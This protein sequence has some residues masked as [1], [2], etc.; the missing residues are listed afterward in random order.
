MS[1]SP[2]RSLAQ[3]LTEDQARQVLLLQTVEAAPPT[4]LW[5]AEDRT[6]AT[7]A[8]PQGLPA[9]APRAA[10]IAERARLAL[11]RL[12][13]RDAALRRAVE[14][15]AWRPGWL[16]AA[17][18][19]GAVLGGVSDGLVA[20]AYFNLLSPLFWGLL[21]WN[22]LLYAA[23]ALPRPGGWLRRGLARS[24]LRRVRGVGALADFSARW[25][26][27]SQPLALARAAALLHVLAAGLAL[28]LIV[29]LL[30]R[31]LVFDYRAGWATT[32]LDSGSVRAVLAYGFEPAWA[33]IGRMP[34]DAATTAALRV[35]P[36]QP[37]T[38]SAA[39]WIG[40]M[41]VQLLALVVLPRVLLA[42]LALWRAH[43]LERRFPLAVDGPAFERWLL[44][45]S[46]ALWVLPQGV[47]PSP[48][49]A[50]G[51][52]A[53]LARIWGDNLCLTL[54]PPLTW[55]EE[56]RPPEPP[57][58]ARAVLLVDLATTPEAEVHGRLLQALRGAAPIVVA[59]EAGFVRRFG[60]GDRLAQRQGAW[61]ALL[62]ATPFVSVDL[63]SPDLEAAV[64]ALQLALEH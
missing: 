18:A 23:L 4:P 52:R 40:L 50:L 47:A 44:Q 20:G 21:A 25:A 19:L 12:A 55:G 59:D 27:A 58:G 56:D 39:P 48:Q 17:L 22:L 41:A 43:R 63:E 16:L 2:T 11:Q 53:L 51:L 35:M 62:A 46:A 14:A 9:D 64:R 36:G 33:L 60:R 34:P 7:R 28:G 30:L 26:A 31:G 29:G 8:A 15:R 42:G 32:L 57:A 1:A 24:L 37:A 10:L 45:P 3:D 49:A 61:R 6:W 38:L 54:A 5:T 13:P